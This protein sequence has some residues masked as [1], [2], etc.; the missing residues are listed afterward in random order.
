[1]RCQNLND[2]DSYLASQYIFPAF[3]LA[4]KSLNIETSLHFYPRVKGSAMDNSKWENICTKEFSRYLQEWQEF[5]AFKSIST[6][7]A[8]V[9]DCN[10]CAKWLTNHLGSI[11][12]TAKILE[13][14]S[15]PVVFAQYRSSNPSSRVLYYGHYDVQP[16]DPLELWTSNPFKAEVRGERLYARG[17]QDNKG[18]SFYFIKACEALIREKRLNCDLTILLEG[19]EES[20]SFGLL[21]ALPAWKDKIQADYLLVCDTGCLGEGIP[22]ITMGLRGIVYLTATLLG[23]NHDLHSGHYG[24]VVKNP[25]TELARLMAG[26]HDQNGHICVEDFYDGVEAIGPEDRE[27]AKQFPMDIQQIR[28]LT[29]V[30]PIG[31]ETTFSPLE[32]SAFRPTIEINGIYAGYSGPGTKTIIPSRAGAKI[33]SRL[34][35]NQDPELSLQRI[36][37]HLQNHAPSGLKLEISEEGVGGPAI[38]LK[39]NSE[40]VKKARSVLENVC[41]R[42]I[43]YTWSG[44]SIPVV[45]ILS[46]LSGATPLLVGFG[47]E[48]DNIHAP[49]ESF[50]LAQWKQGFLYVAS[51]LESL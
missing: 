39:A 34:V 42:E 30:E 17:A 9:A 23:P 29:G 50:S 41:S 43:T 16:V 26:L 8:Y 6:D 37:K 11:G 28:K 32:R 33:T 10:D 22:T 1:M 25:A 45:S 2:F 5:L 51:I 47:L 40:I 19:E 36:I 13:T 20:S 12:F 18:Q 3:L 46:K 7:P 31:G 49:N 24:G 4:Q 27:L 44:G 15:K 48:E 21:Q 35:G 14:K 38:L